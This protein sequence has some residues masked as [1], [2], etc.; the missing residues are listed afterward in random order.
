LY[1]D[2]EASFAFAR[3]A[4]ANLDAQEQDQLASL[5]RKALTTADGSGT[6]ASGDP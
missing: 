3:G 1:A 4:V 2:F 6:T 5:L